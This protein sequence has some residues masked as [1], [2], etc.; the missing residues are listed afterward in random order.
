MKKL[1]IT[2]LLIL[3]VTG[4]MQAMAQAICDVGYTTT[5]RWATGAKEEVVL[6]N[7]ST[8]R[9]NW[10]LCW[11]LTGN[12]SITSIWNS[13][14][15][16]NGRKMCVKNVSYNASIPTNGS[17]N[18]G[19]THEGF[20]GARPNDFTLNGVSCA[21]AAI[22]SSSV[23]NPSASSTPNNLNAITIQAENYSVMNGL[24][25]ENTSDI[26]GGQNVGYIDAGD[27]ATYNAV[28]L[29]CSGS[30]LV[31]YRVASQSAGGQLVLERAGGSAAFGTLN[32]T[33]TGGWQ[34]W[35]TVSHTVTL[36]AGEM[37]FGIAMKQ[38][39]WNL[40]WFKV[41]PQ[42][43]STS[44]PSSS[45]KPSSSSTS[46][47]SVAPSSSS[48]PSSSSTSSSSLAPSSSSTPSS[49][50][51]PS[52]SSAPSSSSSS[53]SFVPPS[54][55]P[56][57]GWKLNAAE[58]YLNFTTTKKIHT[59]EVHTFDTLGGGITSEGLANLT[60]DLN[61]VNT[62]NIVRD[63]RMRAMLFEVVSYPVATVTV[64][65]PAG[66]TASLA[67]GQTAITTINANLNLHNVTLPIET[68]VSVQKLTSTRVMV[69]SLSPIILKA[70]DYGM[71]AG[72]EALRQA[73]GIDSISHIVPVDFALVFDGSDTGI[74]IPRSSSSVSSQSSSSSSSVSDPI[75]LGQALYN[76]ANLSCMNCHGSNGKDG[77]FGIDP[78]KTLYGGTSLAAYI[79]ANMPKNKVGSCD[80]DCGTKIAAFIKSWVPASSSSSS[81]SAP[82]ACPANSTIC[83]NFESV[84]LGAV[85]TGWNGTGARVPSVTNTGARSGT[86]SLK[87]SA[88]DFGQ[89]G[90]IQRGTIPAAHYGR[91]FYR[92]DRL[93]GADYLHI[94]MVTLH[95]ATDGRE[96]RIVDVNSPQ[97]SGASLGSMKY[98]IN[99]PND[100]NGAG[101]DTFTSFTA[102]QQSWQCVEW[103]SDPATQTYTV[104][105]NGT[106]RI[107]YNT[108]GL[109]PSGTYSKINVGMI[110]F[111]GSE[112]S[113]WIDDIAVAPS[114]IGCN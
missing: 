50:S 46:S 63:D 62:Q 71:S 89:S 5:E 104:W 14:Y 105:V 108:G 74:F 100:Q 6:T 95:S 26:G 58:S 2:P 8:A 110:T 84:N 73:V 112:E 18:F 55:I 102:A 34:T 107:S 106:Q 49:S 54:S 103:R 92:F 53:S 57:S 83:E 44:A 12:E 109:I 22:S 23:N 68:K 96:V 80:I 43:G 17:V 16:L 81:S 87:V 20:M 3:G 101:S 45:S 52:S 11:T 82:S 70:S 37:R 25:T 41:T 79:S 65:L 31:E 111:R 51:K 66:T 94:P 21:G 78:N 75:A 47:S 88:F 48:K 93:T 42:C 56:S 38:S 4:S 28:N 9:N 85:P 76:S 69:K 40:N 24:Q 67:A 113:A 97:T 30:Y 99:F 77:A 10:E 59:L 29:P 61:S 15:S 98:L 90:F 32:F 64:Q 91:I 86:K 60:I 36:P 27:W 7:R 1:L 13:T 114:R 72:V 33:A 39:G 19:F 35:K